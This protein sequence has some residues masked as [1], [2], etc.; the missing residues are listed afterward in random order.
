MKR[1]YYVSPYA[2][3]SHRISAREIVSLIVD[4]IILVALCA[5]V[6]GLFAVMA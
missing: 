6:M 3:P 2:R 4:A 1:D 5:G